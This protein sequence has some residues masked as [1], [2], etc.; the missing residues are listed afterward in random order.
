M[1]E[2]VCASHLFILEGHDDDVEVV[3]ELKN[4]VQVLLL[5]FG[6][7]LAHPALV[8]RVQDLVNHDVVDVNPVLRQLLDQPLR[9]VHRQELRNA[10]RHECGFGGVLHVFVDNLGVL[11]HLLHLAEDTVERLVEFILAA[12]DGAHVLEKTVELLL[13]R[14]QFAQ[15]L[16]EDVGEVE[17]TQ[18]MASRRSVENYDLEVHLLDRTDQLP[19]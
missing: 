16:L 4:L 15:P 11:L 17:E 1:C 18:R 5:H 2:F 14:E 8:L 3:V 7:G 6:T 9:L 13:E 12:E 10:H 19:E